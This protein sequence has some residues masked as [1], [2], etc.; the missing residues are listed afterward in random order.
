MSFAALR[1]PVR[2]VALRATAPKPASFRPAFR[3]FATETPTP[4]TPGPKS[5]NTTLLALLGA[6]VV[7]GLGFYLYNN[8]DAA[9]EAQTLGKSGEQA[10]KQKAGF[11]PSKE[12][13][14]KVGSLSMHLGSLAGIHAHANSVPDCCYRV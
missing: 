13:Y 12:D 10:L 3:R 1:Q 8:A 4:P 9:K 2:R 5:T 6:G 11:T 14:Q 7:G